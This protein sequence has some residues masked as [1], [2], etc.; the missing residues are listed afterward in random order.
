MIKR[1]LR[2]DKQEKMARTLGSADISH[3]ACFSASTLSLVLTFTK[4]SHRYLNSEGE[5][6]GGGKHNRTDEELL[7]KEIHQEHS[8]SSPC[9]NP[10]F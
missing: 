1:F 3:L 5:T 10:L 6:A 8:M 9:I 4:R 7:A 2:A